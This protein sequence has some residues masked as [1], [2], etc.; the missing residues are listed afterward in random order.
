MAR[1]GRYKYIYVHGHG[2]QLFDLQA[3]P[4]EWHNLA[5]D[6]A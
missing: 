5:G 1:K 2:E 3:D 6:P 4:G